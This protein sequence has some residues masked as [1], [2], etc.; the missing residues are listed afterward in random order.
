MGKL[1]AWQQSGRP[2]YLSITG[3]KPKSFLKYLAF[4]RHAIPSRGQAVN[5]PGNLYVGTKLVNGIQHTLTAWESKEHM[6][7][8]IYS[9]AHLAA[10]KVF[11]SIAT[12]KTFGFEATQLPNWDEV[13]KMWI[14]QGIEY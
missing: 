13:H 12:G 9:G 2:F 6:K 14:E 7:R 8:Y 10:I 5:A 1:E 3:L 4:G 11:R